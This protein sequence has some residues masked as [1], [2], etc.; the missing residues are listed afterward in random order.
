M[1]RWLKNVW[2]LSL[3]EL[4]SLLGDVTLLGLIV[5]F[6]SVAVYTVATGITTEVRNASVAI[7]DEDH[8]QLSFRIRDALQAPYFK[9]PVMI[10][11]DQVDQA[12][13]VAGQRRAVRLGRTDIHVDEDL[14]HR[15]EPEALLHALRQLYADRVN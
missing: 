2:V 9:T 7:I 15:P 1:L 14:R 12:M 13:G 8:S 11:P 3:K 5:V 4:K 10:S 6:L